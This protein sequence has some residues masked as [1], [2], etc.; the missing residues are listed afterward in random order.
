MLSKKMTSQRRIGRAGRGRASQ[1]LLPKAAT[2]I[3][4]LDEITGGGLPKGR[5]SLICGGAGCGKTMLAM[6]FLVRGARNFGEPGR[7]H[8]IRRKCG[9]T[10][11]ERCLD[12][13]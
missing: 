10:W 9:G 5:T 2:G 13:L 7:I 4:G 8:F 11:G 1:R 12:G 6:E 3:Q